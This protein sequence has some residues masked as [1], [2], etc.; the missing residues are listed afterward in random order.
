[1]IVSRGATIQAKVDHIHVGDDTVIGTH[2]KLHSQGPIEIGKNVSIAGGACI[3]GG[4]Y[5]VEGEEKR[6]FTGGPIRIGDDCRI[7]IYSI[8]QDGVSIGNGA[9]VTPSSVVISD[10]EEHAIVMGNPARMWRSRG[11][12]DRNKGGAADRNL[13]PAPKSDKRRNSVAQAITA[14]LEEELFADFGPGKLSGDDSLFDHGIIDSVSLVN[15]V[16]WLEKEFG[17]KIPHDEVTPA[18]FEALNEIVALVLRKQTEA[19]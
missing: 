1:M 6:R 13:Q 15:L 12:G 14:H 16:L 7:G 2:A 9:I 17:V 4:R 3:V 19:A 18:N 11:S 8:V 10:V 5:V